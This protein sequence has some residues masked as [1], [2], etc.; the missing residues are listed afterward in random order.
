M[1][2]FTILSELLSYGKKISTV[3]ILSDCQALVISE[4]PYQTQQNAASDQGLHC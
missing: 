2:S 1:Y 4:D 3:F